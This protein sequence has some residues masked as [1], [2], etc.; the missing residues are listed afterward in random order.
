MQKLSAKQKRFCQE[1][2]I[3]LNGAQ[4]AIRAGYSKK[5]A[6][7]QATR[8]LTKVHVQQ[9]IG[10][11][12]GKLSERLEITADKVLT[13]LAKIGFSNIQDFVE[14]NNSTVDLSQIENEKAAAVAGVKVTTTTSGT[15]KNRQVEKRV[16]FKLHDKRA[17]LES[18][19]KHLGVFEKDNSQRSKKVTIRVSTKKPQ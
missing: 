4:A 18:L 12:Q 5:T 1:Y 14:K 2:I 10:K 13:E 16:E 3:D 6:K 8:L 17:A 15:G 19:G 9:C 7:E 11:L